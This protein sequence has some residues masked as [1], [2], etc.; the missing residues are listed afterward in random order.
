MTTFAEL[1]LSA[2]TLTVIA[3]LGFEVPTP[4]QEQTTPALLAGRDVIAQAPTGTG[5][6][7]AYGLPIVE[8]LDE[9][10]LLPQ[11]LVLVPT[12]ELA[13]QVAEALHGMGQHRQMVTLPIYGGQPYD[14][15]F[16]A[17]KRGVQVVVATPGR[18]LDHLERKTLA[19]QTI[20]TVV[21][22]E[23]DEMLNMGFIEDIE[24]ILSSVPKEHQTALFSATLPARVLKLAG[25]YLKNPHRVS[26]AA[27]EAVAPRVRQVYY[28]VA[29]RDKADALARVLDYEKPDSAIVFVRTKR[30][31]DVVAEQL[32]ATGYIAQAIHGDINQA[33]RERVLDR[34]RGGHT[35]L[36]VG[37]DVAARGLDIPDV[38]HIINYDL[39]TDAESYVHRIGRTGRAGQSG[40]ALTLVTPGERRQLS[41]IEHGIHRKILPLRLPTDAQIAERRRTA[42][43][44]EVLK[45]LDAGELDPFIE[46]VTDLASSRDIAEVAAAALKMA[47]HKVQPPARPRAVA[48]ATSPAPRS[49]GAPSPARRRDVRTEPRRVDSEMTR[50]FLRVGKKHGVRP[51]D[52]VGAIANE[53]GLNGDDIGDI[54]LYDTFA[55]VEVP[56]ASA[57]AVEV[58]L[59]KTQIRGRPPR[60]S[61]AV[62]KDGKDGHRG[63]R[64]AS[65]G[66][67]PT[68][69]SRR[70]DPMARPRGR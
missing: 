64:P 45:I 22:D 53:A 65:D 49:S 46:M 60:A 48:P 23:A 40:E 63:V 35:Q 20:R 7:A 32:N 18:L 29:W 19:L 14:R 57:Q 17:L 52:V 66:K 4:V 3:D 11:A 47:A 5:K 62:A 43:R 41:M 24:K 61:I 67:R 58:A 51:A 27:R 54:D 21:L 26:V 34:F 44:D 70:P 31:A 68:R 33:Q 1:G 50:L 2:G 42:F 36:L 12:R 56:A 30:D 25:Q 16:R 37:T 10:R 39:P 13:I 38:T 28:E 8:R 55:F 9:S 69:P 59:N 15:Q 6:T